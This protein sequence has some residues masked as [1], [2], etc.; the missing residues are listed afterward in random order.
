MSVLERMKMAKELEAVLGLYFV[1]LKF[2]TSGR[3]A[4]NLSVYLW[5]SNT[6]LNIETLSSERWTTAEIAIGNAHRMVSFIQM[7]PIADQIIMECSWVNS[8][9][10]N[11]GTLQFCAYGDT[12]ICNYYM[13]PSPRK[14]P[15][16]KGVRVRAIA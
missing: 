3:P 4:F 1:L 8:N 6:G 9:Q 12:V 2:A 11:L 14:K 5:H 13:E 16:L 15:S 10:V 7:S